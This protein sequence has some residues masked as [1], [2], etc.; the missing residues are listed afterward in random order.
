MWKE[1][2]HRTRK[3]HLSQIAINQ[4]QRTYKL[5]RDA[6]TPIS[7]DKKKYILLWTIQ[8]LRIPDSFRSLEVKEFT[9]HEPCCF[10]GGE[11]GGG[12]VQ[13]YEVLN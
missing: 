11:G 9:S 12:Y 7:D 2:N 1:E 4:S 10:L 6:V 8:D 5:I 3:I 13:L